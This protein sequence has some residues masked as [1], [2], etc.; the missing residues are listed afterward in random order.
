MQQE[1]IYTKE[2]QIT[3]KKLLIDS[4]L[5]FQTSPTLASKN[6]CIKKKKKVWT[7]Y[8]TVANRQLCR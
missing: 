1:V 4:P 6:L 2:I 3:P 5:N 8:S 7:W